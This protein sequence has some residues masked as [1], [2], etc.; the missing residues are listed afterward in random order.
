LALNLLRADQLS[1]TV[2]AEYITP[3][4]RVASFLQ[5]SLGFGASQHVKKQNHPECFEEVDLVYGLWKRLV[6][7]YLDDFSLHDLQIIGT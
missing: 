4:H 7:E 5:I 3:L 1:T 2:L 6:S